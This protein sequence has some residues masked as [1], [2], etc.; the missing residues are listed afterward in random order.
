MKK[1]LIIGIG[2]RIMTDDAIGIIIVEALKRHKAYQLVSYLIGETDF[3]YCFEEILNY[4]YLVVVD[5]YMSGKAPGEITEI[6]LNELNSGE[7]ENIYSMHG[8]H[9]LNLLKHSRHLPEGVLI[10]I[11]PC[12][13]D[14]GFTLSD[15]LQHKYYSILK[16]VRKI[17][18]R[19]V[20]KLYGQVK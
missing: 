3:D 13:I 9:L 1:L 8:I 2:S 19:H 12:V 15:T 7:D 16:D 17:I 4:D 20:E 11:E 18:D 14:Y 6:P 5:A 10:G